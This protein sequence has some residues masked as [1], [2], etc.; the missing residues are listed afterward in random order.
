MKEK[1]IN[2]QKKWADGI[3]RMGELS[4]DISSL[5]DYAN[6]F[7]EEMYD[8]EN[9]QLLFKPT[10]ASKTQFRNTREMTLSYFIAGENKECDEDQGFALSKWNKITFENSQITI[11]G[12]LGFAMGNYYFENEKRFR[13]SYLNFCMNFS[14]ILKF[15][16]TIFF[17]VKIYFLS[18]KFMPFFIKNECFFGFFSQFYR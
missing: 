16:L 14:L 1:I 7:L 13:N 15:S 3:I 10:K 18:K 5:Q 2:A 4:N 11:N 6:N 9:K 17:P 8:F 12:D